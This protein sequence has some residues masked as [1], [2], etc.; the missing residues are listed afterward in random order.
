MIQ[1][2]FHKGQHVRV[3]YTDERLIVKSVYVGVTTYVMTNGSFFLEDELL[4]DYSD[5]SDK[6]LMERKNEPCRTQQP[7]SILQEIIWWSLVGIAFCLLDFNII[8]WCEILLPF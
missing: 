4:P 6:C 1:P 5:D 7:P 8:F 3:Q 2:L